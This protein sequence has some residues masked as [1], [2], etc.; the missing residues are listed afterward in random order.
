MSGDGPKRRSVGQRPGGS[1]HGGSSSA[2]RR[3]RSEGP[4][5][6]GPEKIGETLERFLRQMGAPPA[7]TLANLAGLW[8]KIVGPALADRTRPV[9]VIDGV[10]VIGCDDAG[11]A[12][13]IGWMDAQIKERFA[14]TFDG[15]EIRRIQVKIGR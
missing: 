12:S 6:E 11:W 5:L 3:R 13:Q 4:S 1:R 2:H 8:P 7:R 9:E 14:Q 10:L 15:A